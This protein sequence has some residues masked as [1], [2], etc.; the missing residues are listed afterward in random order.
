MSPA[1]Q[2]EVLSYLRELGF[3]V[4]AH[5]E[6]FSSIDAVIEYCQAQAEA[7]DELPFETDGLAIKINDLAL[8]ATWA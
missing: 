5:V 1:T 4:A 2:W 7:R 3:P 6:K 8:A